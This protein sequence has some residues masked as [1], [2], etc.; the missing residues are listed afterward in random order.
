MQERHLLLSYAANRPN[1][2][3]TRQRLLRA[4]DNVRSTIQKQKTFN[5]LSDKI[6]S[7]AYYFATY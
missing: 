2:T 1:K 5:N 4:D 3:L 6:S 7:L